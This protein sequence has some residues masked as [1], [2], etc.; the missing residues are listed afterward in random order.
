MIDQLQHWKDHFMAGPALDIGAGDGETSLWLAGQGFAVEALEP[1]AGAAELLR[2]RSAPHA[3]QVLQMDV[4]DFPIPSERYAII[5]ASAVLHFIDGALIHALAQ[6]MVKGL[7]P[8]GMLFAAVFTVDDPAYLEPPL[9]GSARV[10]HFFGRGEL[11]QIFLPL[12][13]LA[14]DESR[15]AA[16]ES[17]YGYRAGATLVARQ[18]PAT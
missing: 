13:V 14:Y 2:S 8:G 17:T 11:R 3:V 12:D 10:L 9:E 15:R 5:V 1:D 16:P 18:P 7:L 6:Q 4:L